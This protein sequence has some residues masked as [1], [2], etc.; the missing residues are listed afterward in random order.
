MIRKYFP[1]A[2]VI[3][4]KGTRATARQKGIEAVGTE[5][6]VFVD[7]DVVLKEGWFETV[8]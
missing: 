5:W 2:K 3:F 8:T 1:E 7:S 4:D 6:F